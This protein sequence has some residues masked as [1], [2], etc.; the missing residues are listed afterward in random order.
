MVE[1]KSFRFLRMV[2]M[3]QISFMERKASISMCLLAFASGTCLGSA[4]SSLPGDAGTFIAPA[5]WTRT[6]AEMLV[7]RGPGRDASEAPRLAVTLADGDP[8][9]TAGSLREGWKRV[10]AGCEMLDD[11][12]EPL[13][14]RVWRRIRVRFAAGPLA[15]AQTAWVGSV[16]GR[17]VV[18]LL[19]APDDR[20]G[21]HLAAASA[22]VASISAPR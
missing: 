14:G 15:F 6:S 11:D 7:L 9:S 10:A 19:S 13:G 4:E 16:S 17:T 20:I 3:L 8:V 12:D 1:R 22:A 18:V 21:L 2:G 5:G